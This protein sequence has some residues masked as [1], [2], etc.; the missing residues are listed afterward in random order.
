MH[1]GTGEN[2]YLWIT[3]YD[4]EEGWSED[5]RLRAHKTEHTPALASFQGKLY[6]VHRGSGSD[7]AL[8]M[9]TSTTGSASSWSEDKKIGSGFSS[10][11]SPSL[12]VFKSKL[13][14]VFEGGQGNQQVYYASYDGKSWTSPRAIGSHRTTSSP[15]LAVYQNKL[16]M[17]IRGAATTDLW[18]STFDGNNWSGNKALPAHKSLEGPGLA[19]FD[20][21]LYCA[22]RG[23]TGDTKLWYTS[24]DGSSWSAD[25]R[26]PDHSSGNTPAL[27]A[28]QDKDA[29]HAQLLCVHRGF[30]LRAQQEEVEAQE[31]REAEAAA[32]T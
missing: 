27:I 8:W 7:T 3:H 30:D 4:P 5:T 20:G 25:T 15:G 22:H 9:T 24:F 14:L 16:H 19:V 2:S 11:S 1:R 32:S 31:L 21:K 12:I 29:V 26:F 6:C 10:T 17:V 13:Y 23:T 18:H 28:Y